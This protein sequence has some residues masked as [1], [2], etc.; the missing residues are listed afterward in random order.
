[1]ALSQIGCPAHCG[2]AVWTYKEVTVEKMIWAI[3]LL[4]GAAGCA[5]RC[6]ADLAAGS[7]WHLA[8]G[9]SKDDVAF[10]GGM[11]RENPKNDVSIEE[12]IVGDDGPAG[13][14]A[15]Y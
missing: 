10:G 5:A 2:D 15:I 7:W 8:S 9:I 1:M 11:A 14:Q 6:I 3:G 12:G 4:F 13:P